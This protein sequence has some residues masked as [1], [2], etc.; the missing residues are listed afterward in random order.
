M[1]KNLLRIICAVLCI[2]QLMGLPCAAAEAGKKSD[3]LTTDANAATGTGSTETEASS[4]GD[5]INGTASA[6][7]GILNGFEFDQVSG[8]GFT[9]GIPTGSNWYNREY[10]NRD[11]GELFRDE[12]SSE[13]AAYIVEG[14]LYL[15]ENL[16]EAGY[17][18][19]PEKAREIFPRFLDLES[20]PKAENV[21]SEIVDI[22]DHPAHLSACEYYDN[23][24]FY[25]HMGMIWY[26]RNNRLLR[27]RVFSVPQGGGAEETKKVT[28]ADLKLLAS[29]IMYNEDKAPLSAKNAVITITAKD[30]PTAVTAGKTLQFTAEF[31]DTEQINKKAKNDGISWS[32]AKAETG[33]E[34]P[35]VSISDKGQLKIG[36]ALDA[37]VPLEV[38]A[39]SKIFGTEATY[40]VTAMP[41]INSLT[42]EPDELFFYTGTDTPRTVKVTLDPPVGTEGVTWTASREGIIGMTDN[43]DGTVSIRPLAAGKITVDVKASGGR[44]ARL[45]V[46]VADPVTALTLTAKGAA[47]PGASVKVSAATEPKNPANKALE[48]SLNVDEDIA[49]IN[50]KGQIRISREAPQGTKITVTCKALGAPEP[51]TATLD[52][53]VGE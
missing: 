5:E 6:N 45:T 42:V 14:R 21:Q 36:K 50:D 1:G 16:I 44:K 29:K 8:D 27:I 26:P 31:A 28:M 15:M 4:E 48:W 13:D 49:A 39:T 25:A 9:V 10:L 18:E 53:V 46:N 17:A 12:Y 23:G 2:T 22:D 35:A 47:K 11:I 52:L 38:K 41:V 7:D 24:T 34:V 19:D 3:E 40:R 37:P 51:V 30:D 20:D 32:A 43:G 33:E